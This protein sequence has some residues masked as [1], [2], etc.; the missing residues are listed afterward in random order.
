MPRAP[1]RD[2]EKACS[3]A[4]FIAKLRRHALPLILALAGMPALA[5]EVPPHLAAQV[6]RLV[7]LISDGYAVGLPDTVQAQV[8][9]EGADTEMTIALF[10]I[11]G[12]GG[13]NTYAQYLAVFTA[14]EDASGQPYY[15]LM[16]SL[17]V[18]GKGWRMVETLDAKLKP[19]HTQGASLIELPVMENAE[20]DAPGFPSRKGSVLL[21]LDGGRLAEV[22]R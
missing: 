4:A 17:P 19:G 22:K 16:D 10:V 5:A 14:A 9:N 12:F 13:G 1:A 18:G 3:N 11:E 8:M 20:D 21:S 2:V 15:S 6:E 7:S